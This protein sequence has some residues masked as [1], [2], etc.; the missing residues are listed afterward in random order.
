MNSKVF[1]VYMWLRNDGTPYYVGKGTGKRAYIKHWVGNAPPINRM[2]FYIA[3]DEAEAFETEA[4]LIWYYGRKDLGTGI[5]R[6]L[7]DGGEGASG[8]KVSARAREVMRIAKRGNKIWQ[9][10][11]HTSEARAKIVA[12]NLSRPPVS[13]ETRHKISKAGRG[14]ALS[15]EHKAKLSILNL[16]KKLSEETRDKMRRAMKGKPSPR[17]G[18][19]LSDATKEKI[20][21]GHAGKPFV[22]SAENKV[23]RSS[24]TLRKNHERWHVSRNIKSDTCTLCTEETLDAEKRK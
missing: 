14:R 17:K 4:F 24:R 23:K 2:V 1:Y 16:G 6:N 9:G 13:L 18:A 8:H 5:L 11:K 3:K 10:K 12:A 22:E 20:R 19:V 7:T 15:E 21:Q